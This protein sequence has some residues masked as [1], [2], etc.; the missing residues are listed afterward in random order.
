MLNQKIVDGKPLN[1]IK[2]DMEK[3]L[4]SCC[5]T[6]EELAKGCGT[7]VKWETVKTPFIDEVDWED[8]SRRPIADDEDG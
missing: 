2:Y 8:L 1:Y 7:T 3:F 6:Y 5:D 4:L